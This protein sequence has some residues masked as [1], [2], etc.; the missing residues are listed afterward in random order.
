M[1]RPVGRPRIHPPKDPNTPKR[2]RGRPRIHPPKDPEALKRP[3]GRP[4]TRNV[5]LALVGIEKRPVGRPRIHPPKPKPEEIYVNQNWSTRSSVRFPDD[6]EHIAGPKETISKEDSMLSIFKKL[7]FTERVVSHIHYLTNAE[8][9]K[10]QQEAGAKH[11]HEITRED[12]F[13]YFAILFMMC[14]TPRREFHHYW[15]TPDLESK[16]GVPWISA[17]MGRDAWMLVHKYLRYEIEWITMECVKQM[18]KHWAPTRKISLDE[19]LVPYKGVCV[20]SV[21]MC[22]YTYLR[23]EPVGSES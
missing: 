2:G 16:G 21:G 6:T 3:V 22:A 14:V 11:I 13:N 1:V 8:H 9:R 7:F 15:E 19:C 17:C 4:R 20:V 18:V 10:A 5:L 12:I 23:V